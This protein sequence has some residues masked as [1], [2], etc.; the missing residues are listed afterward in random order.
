[1]SGGRVCLDARLVSGVAGGVE[2]VL[3]GMAHGLSRLGDAG[4]EY[5]F[6]T[7]RGANDWLRPYLAG[8]C[9]LLEGSPPPW[10][11]RTR[12]S[13]SRIRA[14]MRS[15]WHRF[16]P[17]LGPLEYRL[18]ASD[19]AVEAAGA[20]VMHFATQNGFRTRLPS[21]YQPFDLQHIHLPGNFTPRDRSVRE[22]QYRALTAQAQVVVVASQWSKRDLMRHYR[23]PEEKVRVIPLAPVLAA[24]PEPTPG[25]IEAVRREHDLPAAFLFYPAQTWEHKNHAALFKALRILRSEHDLVVPLVCT[26]TKNGYYA[27]L[28]R[29]QRELGV[30]DQVRFLGYVSPLQMACLYRSCRAFAFPSYFEGF[31]MP[32]LEAFL[33]GAPVVCSNA[34]SLPEVAGDAALLFDPQDAEQLAACIRRVWT[35]EPVWQQLVVR[36]RQRVAGFS[37]D[38]TALAYRDLYRSLMPEAGRHA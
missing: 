2:Q 10:Q 38:A 34:T 29:M 25:Q 5:L 8:R 19:G 28:E 26:G 17:L 35:E 11:L 36:G 9:R 13:S 24:Y 20:G 4:D 15:I 1:M 37:W 3:I 16:S 32:V 22:K 12:G 27:V 30:A 33:A 21:I 6:L 18:P 23:L 14:A 7:Y 31:G